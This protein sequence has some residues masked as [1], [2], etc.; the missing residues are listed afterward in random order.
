[1]AV[2]WSRSQFIVIS[3]GE[4]SLSA[5]KLP[6]SERWRRVCF[7]ASASILDPFT[8][9]A[10]A[11]VETRLRQAKAV[12]QMSLS[13]FFLSKQRDRDWELYSRHNLADN[14]VL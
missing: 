13:E 12:L 7:L 2:H 11:Q 6:S 8:P 1:M 10:A 14:V 5:L 3:V 9:P 4:T